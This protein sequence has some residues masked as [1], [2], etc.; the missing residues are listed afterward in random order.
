MKNSIDLI[1]VNYFNYSEIKQSVQ[2]LCKIINNLNY[3]FNI[4]ILD[5]SF[6]S[7]PKELIHKFNEDMK[8]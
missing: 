6:T 1:Y 4:F 3:S 2:S 8:I 7:V 5:N